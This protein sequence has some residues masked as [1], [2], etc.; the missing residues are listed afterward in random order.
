MLYVGQQAGP[1]AGLIT[2][3]LSPEP[4]VHVEHGSLFCRSRTTRKALGCSHYSLDL[5][6]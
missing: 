1:E 2:I 5:E 6:I 4:Q 3:S